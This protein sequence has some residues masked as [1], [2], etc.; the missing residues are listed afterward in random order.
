M[1]RSQTK[2]SKKALEAYF[3]LSAKLA[4]EAEKKEKKKD[5]AKKNTKTR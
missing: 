5:D 2:K 1:K 4:Q 3:K